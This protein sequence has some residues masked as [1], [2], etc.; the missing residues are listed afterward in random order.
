[1]GRRC[2]GLRSCLLR[3]WLRGVRGWGC[4]WWRQRWWKRWDDGERRRRRWWVGW[5]RC[6]FLCRVLLLLGGR[7]WLLRVWFLVDGCPVGSSLVGPRCE[8]CL[9]GIA[10]S[11]DGR[12]SWKNGF[13]RR[14]IFGDVRWGSWVGIGEGGRREAGLTSSWIRFGSWICLGT[15][16][17]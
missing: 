10:G 3:L 2:S 7:G 11:S 9:R 16:S 17:L 8:A 13:W 5:S 4:R 14:W 1:M 15:S 12:S 6:T